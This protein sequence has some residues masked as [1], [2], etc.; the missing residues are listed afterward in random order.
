M[1]RC[2]LYTVGCLILIA[3]I[4]TPG[5]GQSSLHAEVAAPALPDGPY[6]G[7][8]D[9]GMTPTIFAPGLI[10]LPS[11]RET[12]IA[13]SPDGREAFIGAP[14]RILYTHQENGHWS[15]PTIADFLGTE[16]ANDVEPFI[17][18]DGQ[19]FLFVRNGHIWLSARE[20]GKWAHPSLLP[21][22]INSSSDESHP[23][24]TRDRTL[25]FCSTRDHVPGGY[26]SVCVALCNI[27]SHTMLMA[28]P[29]EY[30]PKVGDFVVAQEVKD[31]V[32]QVVE[33]PDQAG[34]T[35]VQPFSISKQFRHGN[36]ISIP[37]AALR[38][39]KEDASQAAARIQTAPLPGNGNCS[40]KVY[41]GPS[42]RRTQTRTSRLGST[43][44]RL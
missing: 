26:A 6:F 16:P 20:N 19:T 4:S 35:K 9:P 3:L 30:N 11:R 43:F 5:A 8:T 24:V 31:T 29:P 41:T 10:S 37:R 34:S 42:M 39:F 17:S 32:L 28:K 27:T 38:L 23:T 40:R 33:A 13:F 18:P 12:K 25:Y 22:P 2:S 15:Q 14:K 1:S 44:S 21:P 7:Q 36:I